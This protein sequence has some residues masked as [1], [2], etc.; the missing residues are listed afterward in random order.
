MVLTVVQ[1]ISSGKDMTHIIF[2]HLILLH[3]KKKKQQN[4]VVEMDLEE[5]MKHLDYKE[6]IFL[7][8]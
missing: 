1:V 2:N 5:W 4:I 7:K 3:N 8:H 6:W